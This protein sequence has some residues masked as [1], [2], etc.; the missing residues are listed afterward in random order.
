LTPASDRRVELR[1]AGII[2]AALLVRGLLFWLRGEYLDWDEAMYLLVA[3]SF[4]EGGEPTLNGLPHTALGP[5]V[6]LAS[7][8]VSRILGL[9]LLVVQRLLS[10]LAGAFLILPVWYLL[11]D[12]AGQ[13]VAWTAVPLLVAWPALIDVAPKRTC[14]F[15]SPRWRVE[16][17]P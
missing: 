15:C 8:A 2:A 4:L 6:P 12:N 11:R 13:R 14:S 1:L 17:P 5:F 10:A 7:A 3:R 9:E 16:K